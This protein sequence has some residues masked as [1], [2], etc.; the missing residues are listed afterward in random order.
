MHEKDN[1]PE[2]AEPSTDQNQ[3]MIDGEPDNTRRPQVLTERD[4]EPLDKVKEPKERR[5]GRELER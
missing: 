3:N 5:K 1:Y 2:T 4:H